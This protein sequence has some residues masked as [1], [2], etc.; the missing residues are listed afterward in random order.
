MTDEIVVL[1]DGRMV[2]TLK[3]PETDEKALIAAM[4]GRDIGDTYA[5][6]SRNDKYGDILLEVEQSE[7]LC[8][9]TTSA[10][11]CGAAR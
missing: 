11:R 6:L 4:V 5:N 7:N 9:F 10:S 1:K 3:T 8:R 2:K